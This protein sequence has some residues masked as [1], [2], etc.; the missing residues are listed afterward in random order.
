MPSTSN[1]NPPPPAGAVDFF[2]KAGFWSTSPNYVLRPEVIESYYYAFR[3]TGDQK[4]RDWAWEAFVAINETTRVG[5]GFS[6]IR[7]VNK[8][9]G[10]GYDDF[11]ESFWFAEVLKY[12]YL[13]HA[14]VSFPS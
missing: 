10:G 6:G 9:D 7:D 14:P 5:S 11:Q 8:A 2:Q 1:K 4:Y 12:S 13:I 3:A